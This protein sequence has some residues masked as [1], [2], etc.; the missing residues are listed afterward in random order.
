LNKRKKAKCAEVA[1]EI[2]LEVLRMESQN[3]KATL[4]IIS[5]GNFNKSSNKSQRVI[6]S[7][8][9][10]SINKEIM[11][12]N[13][14][15]LKKNMTQRENSRIYLFLYNI[16]NSHNYMSNKDIMSLA[17]VVTFAA[18]IIEG[19]AITPALQEADANAI[20]TLSPE[21]DDNEDTTQVALQSE[22]EGINESDGGLGKDWEEE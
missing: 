3:V 13:W 20:E 16:S 8:H 10:S 9:R 11:I 12:I 21:T 14:I 6:D 5:T 2:A 18:F 17:I 7:L 4:H 19:F 1:Q 22:D 15:I